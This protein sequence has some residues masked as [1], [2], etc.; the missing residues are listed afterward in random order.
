MSF[1]SFGR[2]PADIVTPLDVVE[3]PIPIDE[4]ANSG[5]DRDR[6]PKA[7]MLRKVIDIG[8]GLGD[9]ARLHGQ[10]FAR[11]PLAEAFF[12]HLDIAP[13]RNGSAIAD[14]E[15]PIGR[16]AGGAVRRFAGP[17][18]IGLGDFVEAPHD[19]FD[20]V[21]DIGE[22]PFVMAVV[23]DLDRSAFED[24]LGE[25]EQRHVRPPP[26]AIDG[27][28]A[29]AGGRQAKEAAVGVRHQL[30]RLLGGRIERERMVDIVVHGKRH[31]G[32]GAVDGASRGVDEMVNPLVAAT[33]ENIDEASDIAVGIS[34][35]IFE[36]IANAR[37]GGEM[38][39]AIGV[40]A[41]EGLFDGVP[42]FEIPSQ[43][44]EAFMPEQALKPSALQRDVVIVVEIIDAKHLVAALEQALGDR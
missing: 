13:E 14:I 38:H 39:D 34:S 2:E 24:V 3:I 22:V 15:Q 44:G 18:R 6:R 5:L 26:G 25:Q 20:N 21:V 42:V 12:Q 28:E 29:E 19:A 35:W 40:E 4:T 10:E 9:I 23:E 8:A 7:D 32:V 16:E 17:G 33:F 27:E 37:L 1:G 30:V 11:G 43:V 36:R 31:R 41:F